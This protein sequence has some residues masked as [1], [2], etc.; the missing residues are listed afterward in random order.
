M[1][2][3]RHL[4][5]AG[6]RDGRQGHRHHRVVHRQPRDRKDAGRARDRRQCRPGPDAGR[7]V[8]GDRQ[9]RRRDREEPRAGV[10]R[11]RDP[12]RRAVLRR[13]RRAVRQAQ[14]G[15]GRARPVRQ[16]GGRPT[17][18]SG[19]SSSTG[20]P[21]WRPISRGTWTWPSPAGCTS[22]CTSPIPTCRPGFG[23]G[24]NC[25][26]RPGRRTPRIRSTSICWRSRSNWPAAIC[27]TSCCPAVYDAAIEESGLGMRHIRAA[28]SREYVKL[29][30]RVPAEL[31]R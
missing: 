22:S 19:W 18:C 13:G 15:Q 9:V 8:R 3:T 29:G 14:R 28:A 30:R 27:A 7:P 31:A 10:R 5:R 11:G 23:S 20:S 24:P 4:P 12:E 16:P 6:A 17:C 2:D 26:R 1:R 25:S 21:C